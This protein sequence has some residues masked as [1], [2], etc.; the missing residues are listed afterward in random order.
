MEGKYK[1]KL[2]KQMCELIFDFDNDTYQDACCLYRVEKDRFE[3]VD[4]IKNNS[5]FQDF[6]SLIHINY[7]RK[8]SLNDVDTGAYSELVEKVMEYIKADNDPEIKIE[9]IESK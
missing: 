7:A 3:L 8:K 2:M 9:I 5:I 1:L 4:S 6:R